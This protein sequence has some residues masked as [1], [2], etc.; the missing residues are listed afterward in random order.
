MH[1][2]VWGEGTPEVYTWLAQQPDDHAVIEYP[3]EVREEFDRMLYS[4]LHRKKI[5]NGMSGYASNVYEELRARQHDFPSSAAFDDLRDLGI[6]WVILHRDLY[7]RRWPSIANR[8]DTYDA[9]IE[10]VA[11][12][13]D[14]LGFETRGSPWLSRDQNRHEAIRLDEIWVPLLKPAWTVR[15]SVNDHLSALAVDGDVTSRW[16]SEPQTPGDEFVVDFGEEV[17]FGNIVIW[18]HTHPHDYPRGYRVEVSDDGE[19][20][21]T[22][23]RAQEVHV[24]ITRFIEALEH[25]FEITFP[26]IRARHLRIVQTGSH[27]VYVWSI[28]ELEVRQ[29]R[30]DSAP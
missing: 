20:W 28:H 30:S 1:P 24:P 12:L 25:P 5:V 19:A 29:A 11:E 4:A 21:R 22:I 2:V 26:E 6:R 15:A 27:P 23:A 3:L 10:L 16:N 18:L 13:G 7:G 9:S 14:A 8:L 17:T